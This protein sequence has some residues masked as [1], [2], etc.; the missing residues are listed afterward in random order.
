M[1]QQNASYGEWLL[2]YRLLILGLVTALTLLSASGAQFLYFDNDYRV[3][4]GKENPQLKAFEQIQQTYTK[5]DNVNFAVDPIAGKANTPEVLSA[6]EELTDIAWQLPFSIRVDS[7][8][9]YQHTEVDGD[10]LI[11]RD[12]YIDAVSMTA[13]EQALVDRVST[14]EPAL[15]GK[16]HD[17]QH[18]ATSVNATIQMPGK[19]ADEVNVVAAA[20][21]EMAAEIETKHNVKIRLGGVI[22]LN[23]AFAES[24]MLD[25]A[26]LVPAMY[27]VILIVAYLL[28]RSIMA[29]VLVLFVVVPSIM[30]AMGA[31]GWMGIGL[32][33][34]SASAPTIITT[35]AVADSIHLLV[36]MFNRMRAGYSQRDSLL[37]SLRVNGK[38]IFLTSLTTALGFL[39]MN[40]SDSPPFHDLGNITAI[41]VMAAWIYSIVLLPILI[42]FVPLKSKATLA[43][44]DDKMG[45]LG[46]YVASRYK[47]VLTVSVI[48][49]VAILS[50]IPLNEIN[51]DFVKYFDESVQYRQD[52]DWIST[53][54]TGVNQVQFSLPAGESNGVSDPAFIEKVSDFTAWAHNEPVVTHVQSI[55]DTFKRLNR[56]LNG[57]DPAFYRVPDTRELAA[58]YLLLYELS[59]PFG[60]DLNNQLDISKSSTQVIV[61]IDDMT[62]NELRAWIARA[63]SYLADELDFNL[64]AVGPTV[65]FAYISERNVQS[66]LLGTLVAVFLISGVI[67]IA[68]RDVRLG[69]ISLVPN[70]LPAALAF[71]LWG[72]FVGQVN[73]AVAVVAGMALGV[74]VD[75]SV[76][77]LS[78]YQIARRELKLS[79]HDAVISAFNGVGTAL[80]VTT[81]I[82]TAGFAILAQSTFGVN[83]YMAML[84]GIALVIALIADMTLLPA[85]LIALDKNK[86]DPAPVMG[87]LE[88]GVKEAPQNT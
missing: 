8:S 2:K 45:K 9:N 25:M 14:T 53:N 16:I 83:S 69:I 38:P 49:S 34:P 12:L 47:S 62:T 86:K 7:L 60:L 50:L 31:G 74:V 58:Q 21:R 13:D 51:D 70:L 61:T 46:A 85:L 40:F 19:S 44:L 35:L 37:Y 32:T 42:S 15:A 57:G 65:M 71:G 5:I 52:T 4:F 17:K 82:L 6:V 18:R 36:S 75:D 87:A 77:F 68:L 24:S 43:K 22:F 30:V 27:L 39:S 79:A 26:T 80:V 63:E 33:P 29:T 10:D 64:T 48:I 66:M 72:L 73:M 20:A 84:T 23:N 59:L 88:M 76:H 1:T 56:D 28:L 3:F 54:L 55:S 81:L 78:K 11:V 67:L 41:G